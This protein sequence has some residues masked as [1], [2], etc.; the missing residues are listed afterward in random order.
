MTN[1]PI[2]LKLH[3]TAP[4]ER[5]IFETFLHKPQHKN[6][7]TPSIGNIRTTVNG[8]KRLL[9]THK[10]PL[11]SAKRRMFKNN[12]IE[13]VPMCKPQNLIVKHGKKMHNVHGNLMGNVDN[14]D[15]LEC[16]DIFEELER[17]ER[18]N[19]IDD[20]TY[21]QNRRRIPR[22]RTEID[23]AYRH[24][25]RSTVPLWSSYQKDNETTK[26][27]YTLNRKNCKAN[28]GGTAI[29][30]EAQ[31]QHSVQIYNSIEYF[32]NNDGV[33]DNRIVH[34][35]QNNSFNNNTGSDYQNEH[36]QDEQRQVMHSNT[37]QK[38]SFGYVHNSCNDFNGN[39]KKLQTQPH[40]QMY[41]Y[42]TP[43]NYYSNSSLNDY[44]PSQ[45]HQ[46]YINDK[47]RMRLQPNNYT[48]PERQQQQ[49][50]QYNGYSHGRNVKQIEFE[51]AFF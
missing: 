22:P 23:I 18:K 27:I 14:S 11:S 32:S 41:S 43:S 1:D 33:D 36:L 28:I 44:E 30:K 47:H 16:D 15:E 26:N 21:Q 25:E 45:E 20:N 50:Q 31:G 40:D 17:R 49:R 4:S 10:A 3:D 29:K 5:N 39:E 7:K 19:K 37:R 38:A 24:E 9:P 35:S 13:P 51:D 46:Y 48:M 34:F 42:A 6:K 2:S 12:D 8:K